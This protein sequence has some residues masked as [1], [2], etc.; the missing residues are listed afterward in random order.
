MKYWEIMA[1]DL[2]KA[3]PLAVARARGAGKSV[4]PATTTFTLAN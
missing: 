2:S 1:G 4:G 3:V